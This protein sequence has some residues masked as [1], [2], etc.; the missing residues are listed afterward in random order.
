MSVDYAIVC[1][2]LV[3]IIL[4]AFWSTKPAPTAQAPSLEPKTALEAC[5][6]R[7]RELLDRCAPL[8]AWSE[9]VHL[10]RRVELDAIEWELLG[11]ER[12]PAFEAGRS[13]RNLHAP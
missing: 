8:N 6:R 4:L 5:I 2:M 1:V 11:H 3:V 13:S 10:G 12:P 7:R 9:A